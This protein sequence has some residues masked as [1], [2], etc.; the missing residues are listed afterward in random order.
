MQNYGHVKGVSMYSRINILI[1]RVAGCRTPLVRGQLLGVGGHG[2]VGG[3]A[4]PG[5]QRERAVVHARGLDLGAVQAQ[6]HVLAAAQAD[7][8]LPA[9]CAPGWWEVEQVFR[10]W[11]VRAPMLT[12]RHMHAS[13]W[14]HPQLLQGAS[15]GASWLAPPNEPL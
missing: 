3:G 2:E 10:A 6:V 5:Q 11:E 7:S 12:C 9:P 15:G 13:A 1:L 8:H 14:R 4:R